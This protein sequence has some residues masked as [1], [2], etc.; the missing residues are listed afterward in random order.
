MTRILTKQGVDEAIAYVG[1]QET[2]ILQ[3][4]HARAAA[5]HQ[6][7][8]A[9]LRPLLQAASLHDAKGQG[10]EARRLYHDMLTVEPDWPDALH[11]A[12]WFLVGQGNAAT[13]GTGLRDARRD[14]EDA[15]RLVRRLTASDPSNTDWQRDLSVSHEGAGM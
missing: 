5:S 8:R 3:T 6:R 12:F 11:A 10:I 9:D 14:Y 4:V 2:S 7:N 1:T 15:D 13:I